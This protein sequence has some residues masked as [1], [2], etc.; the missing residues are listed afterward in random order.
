MIFPFELTIPDPIGYVELL[1]PAVAG[2]VW[3]LQRL[4]LTVDTGLTTHSFHVRSGTTP[5]DAGGDVILSAL[6]ETGIQ[7]PRQYDFGDFHLGALQGLYTECFLI[8]ALIWG[9]VEVQEMF[10]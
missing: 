9:T 2:R 1:A 7:V 3:V 6:L 10:V 5:V 4:I 8:G